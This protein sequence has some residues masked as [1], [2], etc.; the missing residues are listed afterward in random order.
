MINFISSLFVSIK[1]LFGL[2]DRTFGAVRSSGW[3]VFRKQH[4]KIACTCCGKKGSFLNRLEL[5]HIIPFHIDPSKE[6][7]PTNVDTFCRRCHQLLAHLDNFKSYNIDI[8]KDAEN[9]LKRI[10]TRP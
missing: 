4:I 7:D 3:F 1:Q 5:H 8:K 9:L 6:L 2:E 10:K